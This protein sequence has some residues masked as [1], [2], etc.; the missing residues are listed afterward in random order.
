MRVDANVG[1]RCWLACAG[2]LGREWPKR[3]ADIECRIWFGVLGHG[4]RTR[5][6]ESKIGSCTQ[7]TQMLTCAASA[8]RFGIF[9]AEA[10][11]VDVRLTQLVDVRG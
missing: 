4:L 7:L 11:L 10:W 3:A 2:S 5:V 9:D 8:A 1:W 6:D